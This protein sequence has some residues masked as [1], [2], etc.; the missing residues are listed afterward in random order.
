MTTTKAIQTQYKGYRFRS[1]TEA[2]WAVFFDAL[3][4]KWEYENEGYDLGEAGWY[5]PDFWLPD[6]G[7]WAEVKGQEPSA[8]EK[9]KAYKLSALSK[10]GV[11]IMQGSPGLN[12][13]DFGFVEY[14][15]KNT[16]YCGECF[17]IYD[18]PCHYASFSLAWGTERFE[19]LR[20]MLCNQ[21]EYISAEELRSKQF[22]INDE[23]GR[24]SFLVELDKLYFLRK[25]GRAHPQY[26]N[27]RTVDVRWHEVRNEIVLTADD[28]HLEMRH[29]GPKIIEA[30]NTARSARFE[31][32]ET[33]QVKA[34]PTGKRISIA[35]SLTAALNQ[36][37][38]SPFSNEIPKWLGG[39][40][41]S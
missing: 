32:G 10:K 37:N 35:S 20:R 1:R 15:S 22:C 26:Q 7:I 27:G 29:L 38:K 12:E 23:E 31:H 19:S 21:P 17:D 36:D 40:S 13:V 24:R 39:N 33:P 8:D 30:H 9:Q 11:L 4:V 18:M 5:L 6:M 16:L 2:R 14:S 3:G 41:K 28:R 34:Q 25:H